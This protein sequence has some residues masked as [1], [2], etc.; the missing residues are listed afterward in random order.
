VSA[1]GAEDR[2]TA[3]VSARG[4]ARWAAG[5]PWIYR[6]DVRRPPDPERAGV[7]AVEGPDG[8]E[9][10]VA[11]W[12]P[13]SEIRLRRLDGPGA[14][15][16]AAWWERRIGE[17]SDRRGPVDGDAWRVVHGEA[18]GLPSLVVDRY[19]PV[20]VAQLLSAGL[21]ACRTEVLD[22]IET[23]LRPSG[24]LLRND[25]SVRRHE[26]LPLAVEPARGDVPASLLV[27]EGPVRYRVDP[28]SGQKTGA[29]LDQRENRARAG[30]LMAES[31]RRPGSG[32]PVRALDAFSF[33]GS[34]ALHLA[35]AARGAGTDEAEVEIVAV[36]QSAEALARGRENAAL[37]GL[38]GIRW[39]EGNAFDLLREEDV[40]GRS[41]DLVVLDP[42]AF[43]KRRGALEAALRGYGEI[44]RRGIRLLRPGGR[45]LTFSCSFHVGRESFLRMLATAAA[46]AGRRVALETVLGAAP[47][48]PEVLTIPETGYLKGAVLRALDGDGTPP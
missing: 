31:L 3:H 41:F 27:R 15:I 17:A 45:L 48:H 33:H 7:V 16:D 24:I 42:P 20:V 40:A 18:D 46:D 13:T 25:V 30:A 12:S 32:G 19:G 28:W 4:A 8:G 43:A 23:A 21:E 22:A 2:R 34:F 11:L 38:G 14:R 29:F 10:G 1:T 47:D 39:V 44:N 37:N 5:H 9:I 26:E 35:A 36:D 6:S